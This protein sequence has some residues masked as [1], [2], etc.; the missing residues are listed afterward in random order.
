MKLSDREIPG[1][2]KK[3]NP[4]I[5]AVLLYGPDEGRAREYARALVAGVAGQ[6]PDPFR[7]AELSAA[8]IKEHPAA[9]A[10]EAGQLSFTGGRRV[11]RVRAGPGSGAGEAAAACEI[12]LESKGDALVIVEAGDI[13]GRSAL[14]R[15]F[16]EADDAAAIACYRDEGRALGDVIR[17]TL[18]GFKVRVTPDALAWLEERLGGDRGLTR[19]EIEKLA[20]YVGPGGEAGLSE[21]QAVVGDSADVGLDDLAHALAD[22]DLAALERAFDKL[23]AE[24]GSAIAMLRAGQRQ[25]MRLHLAAGHLNAGRD[26]RIAMG[27]LRPPVF[28]KE[29]PRFRAQLARWRLPAIEAALSRL[30]AGEIDAKSGR[31]PQELAAR[32]CLLGVAR[33]AGRR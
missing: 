7:Y 19:A 28:W 33:L 17:E 14:R 16:E 24:G 26:E 18:A 6:P 20:L 9:L 31:V 1:F 21:A 8:Q 5:R 23:L 2:V 15:M 25:F 4:R 32:D 3:P 27:A 13:D 29:V 12:L 22:G 30:L 11:V 10:D